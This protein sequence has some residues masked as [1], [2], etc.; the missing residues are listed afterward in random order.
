M[1]FGKTIRQDN[2]PTPERAWSRYYALSNRQPFS[3]HRLSPA[4]NS[5]NFGRFSGSRSIFLEDLRV[6]VET[7]GK[8]E[9]EGTEEFGESAARPRPLALFYCTKRSRTRFISRR[10]SLEPALH[11]RDISLKVT[12]CPAYKA[13]AYTRCQ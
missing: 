4:R 12:C 10:Q 11:H 2:K 8:L 1:S 5:P 6:G 9:S 13:R 7:G 3:G